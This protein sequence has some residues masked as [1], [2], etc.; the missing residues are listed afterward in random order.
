M[1]IFSK[2]CQNFQ[3]QL[4]DL[5][6]PV[7][8]YVRNL[9]CVEATIS[10]AN[11]LKRTKSKLMQKGTSFPQALNANSNHQFVLANEYAQITLKDK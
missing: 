10:N 11:F 3:G 6:L 5:D 7:P 2:I 9:K 4:G 1:E 8:E